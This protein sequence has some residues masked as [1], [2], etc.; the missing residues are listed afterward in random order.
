MTKTFKVSIIF[1]LS[2]LFLVLMRIAFSFSSLSDNISGWL[3]SF[4]VQ[5]IGMG[6]IPLVL[7]KFWV[8]DDIKTGLYI[9]TRLPAKIYLLSIVAG[10]LFR[11][12]TV[13]FS[14]VFQAILRLLGYTHVNSAGTIY[15][16]VEVLILEIITTAVFPAIFEEIT[17]RGVTMRL[18]DNA[19][20]DKT[21]IIIMAMLFGLAHQNIVQTG[22]TFVGGLVLA[23][24]AV[25][26]KSIIPGMIIHF[27]NNFFS[28]LSG[29]SEQRGGIIAYYEDRFFD[30]VGEHF[31]VAFV[32]FIGC[33]VALILLL[34]YVKDTM[35]AVNAREENAQ[36]EDFYNYTPS[37][38]SMDRLD[39]LFGF[40]TPKNAVKLRSKWYEYAFLYG[41]AALAL[42]TTVFTFLWGLWR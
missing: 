2:T 32:T 12:I 39:D 34:R 33:A 15:S 26:T 23:Y 19:G 18:L 3:F 40:S 16:G 36:P 30:F 20:D 35:K 17:D 24:L 6:V 28:V 29:Y 1:F 8:K 5:C 7:Y 37:G 42:A 21:K 14:I 27:M 31:F 38:T 13:G 22:Y 9:K 25:K 4:L 10:F 41:A 11:Y